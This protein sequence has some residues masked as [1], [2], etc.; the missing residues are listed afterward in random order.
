M[1]TNANK[2]K[3]SK[4][5]ITN[6]K[7]FQIFLIILKFFV[8]VYKCYLMLLS[9]I[10]NMFYKKLTTV[11]TIQTNLKILSTNVSKYKQMPTFKCYSQLQHRL[12]SK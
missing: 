8:N 2:W 3:K 6:V 5:M 11:V 7:K 9:N 1:F 12:A 4:Q 10:L